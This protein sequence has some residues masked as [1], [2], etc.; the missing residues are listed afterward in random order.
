MSEA[1]E[2]FERVRTVEPGGII[3]WLS[4][5]Q[6]ISR[7]F[8]NAQTED[9]RVIFLGLFKAVMDLAE[10]GLAGSD[11][12]TPEQV[13]SFREAR[14]RE[15]SSYIVQ[16]CLVNGH[17]CVETLEAVTA[18]EV[19]AGRMDPHHTLRDEAVNAMA[20]PHLSRA[21]LMAQGEAPEA[22]PWS[23]LLGK[24]GVLLKR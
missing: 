18:R 12:V 2:L 5:R 24:L 13:S 10:S 8:G 7:K 19:A 1:T 15:Y 9:D 11:Q 21:E 4:I 20:A 3:D 23:G 22:V 6:E 16:E 14:A 17:I